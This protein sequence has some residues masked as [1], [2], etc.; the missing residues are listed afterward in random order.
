MKSGNEKGYTLVETLISITI[1][2]LVIGAM[3]STMNTGFRSSAD[4]RS[5]LYATNALREELETLRRANFDTIV[6]GT[7]TNA[8]INRLNI[9][10]PAAL[11]GGNRTGSV[12]VAEVN[13]ASP[14]ANYRRVTVS[15]TW[16][17]AT[18]TTQQPV[19]I[20]QSVTTIITRRGLN[21]Q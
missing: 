18:G 20:T 8:Q 19:S 5:R 4:S 7:F 14:N 15:V 6:T 17:G 12:T 11:V 13:P 16:T 9:T 3:A 1:G 2:V 10:D 21:G